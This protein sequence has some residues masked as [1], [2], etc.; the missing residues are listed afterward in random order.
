MYGFPH[1]LH[2]DRIAGEED[3]SKV[4]VSLAIFTVRKAELHLVGRSTLSHVWSTQDP[5][6]D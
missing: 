1:S 6:W 2:I 4:K 5:T 3:R